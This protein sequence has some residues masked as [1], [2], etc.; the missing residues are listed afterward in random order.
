MK[1]IT[2]NRDKGG[3][4]SFSRFCIDCGLKKGIYDD[5]PQVQEIDG[6]V[7]WKCGSCLTLTKEFCFVCT[8]LEFGFVIV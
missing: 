7:Y 6:P 4:E 5:G 3:F 2:K 8:C 1:Q